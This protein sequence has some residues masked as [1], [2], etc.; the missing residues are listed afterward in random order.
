MNLQP[1]VDRGLEI[2]TQIKTLQTELK[3]IEKKLEQ[4]GLHGDHHELKDAD[5]EGRRFLARG[6][7][8]IIPVVFTADKLVGTFKHNS[9]VHVKIADAADGHLRDFFTLTQTWENNFDDGKKFRARADATL[10]K[11]APQFI[12][13]C[14]SRDKYG[15]PKSDVKILWDEQEPLS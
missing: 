2:R 3:E 4:A 14:L 15:I 7:R 11:Q 12:T 1:L 8:S 9:P 10:G 6:S 5:R 13:A